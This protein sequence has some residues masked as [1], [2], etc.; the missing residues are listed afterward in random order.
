M[1]PSLVLEKQLYC[2][3]WKTHK[4]RVL[5]LSLRVIR[6]S[7]S[8]SSLHSTDLC[9]LFFLCFSFF[10]IQP[11]FR[12]LPGQKISRLELGGAL[13]TP[14]EKI[15]VCSGSEVKGYT[16]K[17][18]QFLSFEANLTESINAMWIIHSFPLYIYVIFFFTSLYYLCANVRHGDE[19]LNI[20][21]RRVSGADLF[22]CASYI[23]NHYCDCKDQNY[24]LSGDKIN[25]MVC[26]PVETVGRTVPVLA[27]QDRVLRIL[28]VIS[29]LTAYNE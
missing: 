3:L 22:V 2:Q 10:C 5:S 17:G 16:K 8:L 29:V 28:Q 9:S 14:Q 24:F 19:D 11:V 25:D 4:R 12:S 15:F 7:A 1:S 20:V 21:G 26:L 23:Y 18:K 6:P 13:G 27:C